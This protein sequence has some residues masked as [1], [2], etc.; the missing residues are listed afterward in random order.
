MSKPDDAPGYVPNP[1][2]S[3]EDWNEVSDNPEWTAEDFAQARP[4]KEAMPELYAAWKRK[5]G[6]QRAPTKRLISLRLDQD[7]IERFRATGPGWQ[8]RMNEALR[9]A[10]PAEG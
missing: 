2:Y 1:H 10:M 7:V 9:A 3:Q 4:F 6:A 8:A 5:R